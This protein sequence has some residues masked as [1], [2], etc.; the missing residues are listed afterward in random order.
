MRNLKLTDQDIELITHALD[1]TET[2][3]LKKVETARNENEDNDIVK[4]YIQKYTD[5]G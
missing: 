3:Y 4:Y 2:A 5:F 1:K